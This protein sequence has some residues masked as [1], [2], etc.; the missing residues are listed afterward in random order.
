MN[1]CHS[2]LQ[3]SLFLD[4][5]NTDTVLNVICLGNESALV[6]YRLIASQPCEE[7]EVNYAI[8]IDYVC[9]GEQPNSCK[10]SR[11]I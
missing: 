9:Y 10:V 8:Q 7:V 1:A 3:A 6:S 5:E 4:G 11:A 2:S